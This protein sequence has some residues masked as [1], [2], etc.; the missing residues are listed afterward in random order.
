MTDNTSD[1]EESARIV[2]GKVKWFDPAKGYGFVT[3]CDIPEDILLHQSC[4][5]EAGS[6][7]A[8]QGATITCKIIQ[9]PKG[10]QACHIVK[11]D[12]STAIPEALHIASGAKENPLLACMEDYEPALVKWFNR[13]RGYG[14]VTPGAGRPDVF[15]HMETVRR[16]GMDNLIPGQN[17]LVRIGEGPKGLTVIDLKTRN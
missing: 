5:R 13:V 10:L 16:S 8:L 6:E 4:L 12:N 9:S 14:F 3:A 11:I 2:T 17:V 7:M 1:G 15:L